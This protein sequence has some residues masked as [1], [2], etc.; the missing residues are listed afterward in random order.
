MEQPNGNQLHLAVMADC[1]Q[2]KVLT[3]EQ[4]KYFREIHRD[5][6]L[7]LPTAKR[8][9]FSRPRRRRRGGKPPITKEMLLF[10]HWAVPQ[11]SSRFK[12][13]RHTGFYPQ[14]RTLGRINVRHVARICLLRRRLSLVRPFT[15]GHRSA[16]RLRRRRRRENFSWRTL[17]QLTLGMKFWAKRN[18]E[19][20]KRKARRRLRRRSGE[21]RVSRKRK[22]RFGR[23]SRIHLFGSLRGN[24]DSQ[25]LRR[26]HSLF[27]QWKKVLKKRS[28]EL[29]RQRQLKVKTP[30]WF[31]NVK[32]R[33][34]RDVRVNF[35][36]GLLTYAKRTSA[37][38]GVSKGLPGR[39][40]RMRRRRQL[41]RPLMRWLT[42]QRS[43]MALSFRQNL[44]T[45]N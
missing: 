32:T 35:A 18:R 30:V 29:S 9:F 33:N 6:R 3:V 26:N 45:E 40:R 23:A 36:R 25:L 27:F 24:R 41:R 4:K 10:T 20:L 13:L 38:L 2:R 7:E 28:R 31:Q 43:D 16:Y 21:I 8:L 42:W 44:F 14:R 39:R 37:I 34:S 5:S 1:R 22:F 11:P 12:R 19:R 17:S 15:V